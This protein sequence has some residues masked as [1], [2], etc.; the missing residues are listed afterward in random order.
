MDVR[1][2]ACKILYNVLKARAPID[3][4]NLVTHGINM[5]SDF[6]AVYIGNEAVDYAFFTNEPWEKGTNPNEGW[7]NRA[8]EEAMPMIKNAVQGYM[9]EDDYETLLS[10]YQ[11]E[12]QTRLDDRAKEILDKQI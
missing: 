5:A 6:S 11:K 9:S 2:K 3:T 10:E 1:E 8:I 7:I 4:G 12:L